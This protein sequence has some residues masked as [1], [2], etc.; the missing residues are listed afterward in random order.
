MRSL[1]LRTEAQIRASTLDSRNRLSN[2]GTHHHSAFFRSLSAFAEAAQQACRGQA[3]GSLPLASDEGD[4][5]FLQRHFDSGPVLAEVSLLVAPF[6]QRGPRFVCCFRL[7]PL[8]PVHRF[9]TRCF[10]VKNRH[11]PELV[12]SIPLSIPCFA[13][14]SCYSS[15]QSLVVSALSARS[16]LSPLFLVYSAFSSLFTHSLNYFLFY[17]TLPP[18]PSLSLP[19]A[20]LAMAVRLDGRWMCV[21][22]QACVCVRVYV[23]VCA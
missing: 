12:V 6:R 17:S 1:C 4:C 18:S 5:G 23:C 19:P 21:C 22:I 13:S 15:T 11:F 2:L 3:N 16:T 9:G 20:S 10:R 8:R 14:L 7:H